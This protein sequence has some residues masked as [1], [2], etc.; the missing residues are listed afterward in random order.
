[1][2]QSAIASLPQVGGRAGVAIAFAK[3]KL[4]TPYLWGGNGPDA[5]DCSGLVQGAFAAAGI[6]LPR[7]TYEQVYSGYAVPALPA[8]LEPGDVIFYSGDE[9]EA[10]YV[11]NG[12]VIHDPYTGQVV[13]YAP[14]NMLP[15]SGIRRMV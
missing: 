14:W 15:I 12:L 13:Q 4:G 3:S 7:T 9:H 8:D 2:S 1:V 5:Y 11:G 10:I 6:A